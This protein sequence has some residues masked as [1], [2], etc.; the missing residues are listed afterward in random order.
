MRNCVWPQYHLQSL[1]IAQ[2]GG[3]LCAHCR[4][5][6]ALGGSAPPVSAGLTA[7]SQDNGLGRVTVTVTK[8]G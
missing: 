6:H 2:I 4:A 1:P 5:H 8:T 3:I 7:H